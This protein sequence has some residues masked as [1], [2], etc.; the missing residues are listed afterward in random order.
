MEALNAEVSVA[1]KIRYRISPS[2]TILI[3]DRGFEE[4]IDSGIKAS[5]AAPKVLLDSRAMLIVAW[6]FIFN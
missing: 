1:L 4:M 6:T 2:R 3:V 5:S